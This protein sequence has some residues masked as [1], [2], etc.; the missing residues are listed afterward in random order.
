MIYFLAFATLSMMGYM[1][2]QIV[3]RL[4]PERIRY[5]RH[6]T[7]GKH[8]FRPKEKMRFLLHKA[9]GTPDQHPEWAEPLVTQLARSPE[10]RR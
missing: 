5:Q 1:A 6:A 7:R 8:S 2:W 4:R 3:F 9:F 10:Q